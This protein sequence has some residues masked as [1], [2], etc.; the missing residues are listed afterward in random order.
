[1]ALL[2]SSIDQTIVATALH[3]LQHG[4]HTSI[5]WAGWTITIYSVGLVLMLPLVGKFSDQYGRRRVFLFSAVLFTAASLCCG[6]AN[7]IY[8]LIALRA[9]QAVGAAGFTPSATGIVVDHFGEARDRAV[10]LF[11]SIFPIGAVVG[12]IL[13]GVFVAYWSWKGIFLVNVPI[14]TALV[15]L[16]LRY[17]PSDPPARSRARP[18]MDVTGM[19][20]LGVGVLTAMVAIT[21]LGEGGARVWSPQF[22]APVVVA[23]VALGAFVRHTHRVPEPFIQPRM[24]HGAGFGVMN[25]INFLYG[26]AA[27]GLGALVPLYAIER[28]GMNAL[29]AGTLLT[30]RG[31]AVI[32]FSILGVLALRRTGYRQPMFVGF[33][34]TAVG[35]L[36]LA[37]DPGHVSAY[38]WLA[39]AGAVSGIGI[40]WSAPAS[41]NASLQLAPELSAGVAA[42]RSMARQA[43]SIVSISVTT[44]IIAQ[45]RSPGVTLGHI[46]AIF[47]LLLLAVTPIVQRVPEHRGSW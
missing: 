26:G 33:V 43:G 9:V 24:L 8:L 17:V 19:A 28:Y 15:V 5:N 36:G 18:A 13:G 27:S 34:L 11:G 37:V 42:L 29:D 2:M 7:N 21:Y 40:G 35:M 23:L 32:A 16:C 1:M 44:A 6:L 31:L 47:A 41:R 22:V 39:I 30:A 12:P 3:A 4:L 46:F 25:V 10:G 14:G 20:L 38:A 45:S